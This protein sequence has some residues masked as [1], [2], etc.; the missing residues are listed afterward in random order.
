MFVYSPSSETTTLFLDEFTSSL[1]FSQACRPLGGVLGGSIP[2]SHVIL[3][4]VGPQSR[5]ECGIVWGGPVHQ[6]LRLGPETGEGSGA[7]GRRYWQRGHLWGQLSQTDDV[8]TLEH[9]VRA[10]WMES[11]YEATWFIVHTLKLAFHNFS[12]LLYVNLRSCLVPTVNSMTRHQVSCLV[13]LIYIEFL[14]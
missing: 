7:V 2:S 14:L 5:L 6:G 8:V 3:D 9:T 11:I 10:C 1:V 13:C 4:Y 12:L